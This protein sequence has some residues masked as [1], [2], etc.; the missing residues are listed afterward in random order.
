M[1]QKYS[2]HISFSSIFGEG[3]KNGGVTTGLLQMYCRVYLQIITFT[4]W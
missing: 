3:I 4:L 2:M 1:L